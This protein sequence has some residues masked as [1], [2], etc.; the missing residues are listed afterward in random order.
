[1]VHDIIFS[2]SN[3]PELGHNTDA[4]PLTTDHPSHL[5]LV[6]KLR[7]LEADGVASDSDEYI[8]EV[9]KFARA[10]PQ[11]ATK[12]A[13]DNEYLKATLMRMNGG[14][15]TSAPNVESEPT[16][17]I[18]V[19]HTRA[20]ATAQEMRQICNKMAS[21][22]KNRADNRL[23]PL[24]EESNLKALYHSVQPFEDALASNQTEQAVEAI[25]G[26]VRAIS[27]IEKGYSAG[28]REDIESLK[29]FGFYLREFG[30]RGN[31][32]A[33][34]YAESDTTEALEI[35]HSALRLKDVTDEKLQLL[36]QMF[37]TL[38]NYN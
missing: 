32:L 22:L 14:E 21:E 25:Q 31:T 28:V 17:D 16:S 10:E 37:S 3:N 35:S 27:S 7:E 24:V 34:M 6:E 11:L 8:T 4:L 13:E 19:I 2:M 18:E 12:L 23:T 1:M 30:E 5:K 33:R 38:N 29:K 36:A 20:F 9:E 26:V 15:E